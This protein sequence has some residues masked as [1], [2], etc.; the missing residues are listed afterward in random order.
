MFKYLSPL[1]IAQKWREHGFRQIL[2]G[3]GVRMHIPVP[4]L[5]LIGECGHVGGQPLD[6]LRR[7]LAARR[8][9]A[10]SPWR[11]YVKRSSGY[12]RIGPETI[13]RMEQLIATSKEIYEA[14]KADLVVPDS[15][16]F[17]NFLTA[18]DIAR[19]PIFLGFGLSQPMVQ[20][21]TDYLGTVP[22]LHNISLFYTPARERLANSQLLHLDKPYVQLISAFINVIDIAPENGPLTFLPAAK[23]RLFRER[24][25]YDRHYFV[26]DGRV[27]GAEFSRI[28][29]P[30]DLIALTGEAGSG[31]IVDTSNCLHYGSRTTAGARVLCVIQY[32]PAH[33]MR[34]SFSH[35]FD[36]HRYG[37]ETLSRL[38][39]AGAR[40]GAATGG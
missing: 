21:V 25:R 7:K 16:P 12:A 37:R 5:A 6:W 39:L 35:R 30:D 18:E 33:R 31:A 27:S 8:V 29:Q 38:L 26:G 32:V 4:V 14:R 2:F 13:P 40:P 10:G 15:E 22:R 11:G 17:I 23:T 1:Y 24:F 3:V 19:H 34:P 9:L 36:G 20:I 28:F